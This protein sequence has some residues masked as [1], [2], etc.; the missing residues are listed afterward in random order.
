M[1]LQKYLSAAQVAGLTA[2]SKSLEELKK[3]KLETQLSSM[4]SNPLSLTAF[5]ANPKRWS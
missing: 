1:D 4:S 5:G 2:L 3:T